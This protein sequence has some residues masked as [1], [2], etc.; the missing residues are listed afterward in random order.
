VLAMLAVIHT[1]QE[2]MFETKGIVY[3]M[4]IGFLIGFPLFWRFLNRKDE[5]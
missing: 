2:F 1:L 3:L 5:D 4:I